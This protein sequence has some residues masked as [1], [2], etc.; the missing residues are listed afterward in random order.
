MP[1]DRKYQTN[2]ERQAAYR[3]RRAQQGDA[4]PI[5]SLPGRR[6]WKVMLKTASTL[7][8]CAATEMQD[9][10]DLRSEAWQDSQAGESIAQ[11]LE[12]VEDALASLE[13]VTFQSRQDKPV[14]T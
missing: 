7:L 11:M 12:S 1:R 6:R 8:G 10:Y 5:P 2:G 4:E 13:D 14:I 9:Y 3:R